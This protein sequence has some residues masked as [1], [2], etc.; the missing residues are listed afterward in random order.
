[1]PVLLAIRYFRI[2]SSAT[3][4]LWGVRR[5]RQELRSFRGHKTTVNVT[6]KALGA[7]VLSELS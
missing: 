5:H 2:K 4:Y 1:M 6:V 3:G 7:E